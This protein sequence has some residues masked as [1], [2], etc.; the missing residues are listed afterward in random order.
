MDVDFSNAKTRLCQEYKTISGLTIDLDL[1]SWFEMYRDVFCDKLE[2]MGFTSDADFEQLL[3]SMNQY[4]NVG[5]LLFDEENQVEMAA[6]G[7]I[8]FDRIIRAMAEK[9]SH[10]SLFLMHEDLFI[11]FG[12]ALKE[13]Y[14]EGVSLER[15]SALSAAGSKGGKTK[16]KNHAML[17]SWVME[18]S[19]DRT[20]K[21]RKTAVALVK[22]LPAHLADVSDNPERFVF[23]VLREPKH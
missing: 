16:H 1:S 23:D 18:N 20:P 9:T 17:R 6:F 12:F 10:S 21:D 3:T 22:K 5:S 19:N 13:F 4:E 8:M 11:C 14:E 15:R 7:L 2:S